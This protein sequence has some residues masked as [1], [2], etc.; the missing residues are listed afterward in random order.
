MISADVCHHTPCL[1]EYTFVGGRSKA[2][3][4]IGYRKKKHFSPKIICFFEKSID[5]YPRWNIIISVK[6]SM[7]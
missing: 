1:A 3:S 7:V 6:G 2:Y 5:F 4:Y